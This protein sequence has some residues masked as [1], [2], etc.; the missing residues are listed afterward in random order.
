MELL[1]RSLRDDR[2]V[3]GARLA[4]ALGSLRRQQ[5]CPPHEAQDPLAADRDTVLPVQPSCSALPRRGFRSVQPVDD[6]RMALDVCRVD[7]T[8]TESEESPSSA[9]CPWEGHDNVSQPQLPE[10][11]L[12]EP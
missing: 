1:D 2:A 8:K 7:G 4:P 3:M 9:T 10:R 11:I 5:P 6:K 12:L